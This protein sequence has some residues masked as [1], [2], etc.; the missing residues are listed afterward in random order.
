MEAEFLR[1]KES[2][3]ENTNEIKII[4]RESHIHPSFT[5]WSENFNLLFDALT[6][7]YPIQMLAYERLLDDAENLV[8]AILR[9]SVDSK[10]KDW[11][12]V[13]DLDLNIEDALG[14]IKPDRQTQF[15][16]SVD[17]VEI[18]ESVIATFDNFYASFADGNSILSDGLFRDLNKT[19]E[20][21]YPLIEQSKK[22]GRE[23][24]VERLLELGLSRK[25]VLR[26]LSQKRN[27]S[28]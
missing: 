24:R 3:N 26:L 22:A 15:S 10:P 18:P 27:K 14:V 4:L 6:R 20:L 13:K 23:R 11:F 1:S 12:P 8:P 16:Q 21:L 9:W 25:E 17:D 5:W 19:Q 28:R 2:E 7:G